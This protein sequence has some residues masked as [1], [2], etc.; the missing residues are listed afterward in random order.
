MDFFISYTG[1]DR[2]W[3]EWIAWQLEEAGYE[4][5]LQAWDFRP[6][7]NFVHRMQEA[8]SQAERTIA[9][10]SQ[11]YLDALFT[12]P[13]WQAAFV[14]DPTG[15]EGRLVPVRIA[16]CEPQGLLRATIYIDLVRLEDEEE[17]RK[18]LLDGLA[19]SGRPTVAPRFPAPGKAAAPTASPGFPGALPPSGTCRTS[20]TPTSP[21]ARSCWLR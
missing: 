1:S 6:G 21:G 8:T 13:E 18:A 4:V 10:L 19:P 5:E 11:P 12:H 17:A 16:P 15:S 20:A 7:Q 3:A 14:Q 2:Q 9:V